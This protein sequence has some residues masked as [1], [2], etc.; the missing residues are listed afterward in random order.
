MKRVAGTLFV[1]H[2]LP[3]FEISRKQVATL[4][5]MVGIPADMAGAARQASLASPL[6]YFNSAARAESRYRF[7]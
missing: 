7:P 6:F 2:G 1:T 5:E 4:A 3:E